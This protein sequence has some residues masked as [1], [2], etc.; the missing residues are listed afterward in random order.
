MGKGGDATAGGKAELGEIVGGRKTAARGSD[1]LGSW[2][3]FP[4]TEVLHVKARKGSGKNSFLK[5]QLLSGW[6]YADSQHSVLLH[7]QLPECALTVE[8]TKQITLL[9]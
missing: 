6:H 8:Q 3:T 2:S 9:L 1:V 5:T 7:L 4:S